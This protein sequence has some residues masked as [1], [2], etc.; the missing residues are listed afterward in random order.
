M[1]SRKKSILDNTSPMIWKT[2][3]GK[4]IFLFQ[5][6]VKNNLIFWVTYPDSFD[7]IHMITKAK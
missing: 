3:S 4:L 5:C 6:V 7:I 2:V 1:A